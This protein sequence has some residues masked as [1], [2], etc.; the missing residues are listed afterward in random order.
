MKVFAY[1]HI[2]GG[3]MVEQALSSSMAHEGEMMT[4]ALLGDLSA[5][6]DVEVKIRSRGIELYGNPG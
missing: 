5:L 3:G 2:T 1:E 4:P 6:P